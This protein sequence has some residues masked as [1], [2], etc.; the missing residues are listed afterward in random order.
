MPRA[1]AV[2][3]GIVWFGSAASATVALAQEPTS[4]FSLPRPPAAGDPSGDP[5]DPGADTD[6][7]VDFDSD[8]GIEIDPEA[9]QR[10]RQ[11]EFDFHL[12]H[13]QRFESEGKVDDAIREFTA[14]LK[15]QSGDPGALRG[16]AK[17]RFKKTRDGKCPRRAIEDLRLLRLYD[18]AGTWNEER[19]TILDWMALC[20]ER[21]RRERLDLAL[22]LA[23]DD[24]A[25]SYRPPDI[26]YTVASLQTQEAGRAALGRD[27]QEL[28]DVALHQ[29]ERYREECISGNRRP[30]AGALSLQADLYRDRGDIAEAIAIY[31][32]LVATHPGL[33]EASAAEDVVPSSN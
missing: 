18:P 8:T 31:K 6:F 13:A 26:R 30:K 16:R 12:L 11:F 4:G 9:L 25:A 5:G 17:L 23:E 21:Y 29:L 22:A 2:V 7:D 19:A 33:P 1:L 3:A 28:R 20:G 10:Q 14:A 24:P 27:A 32:E 15:L